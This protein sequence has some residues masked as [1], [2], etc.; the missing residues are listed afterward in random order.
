MESTNELVK[1]FSEKTVEL[2]NCFDNEDYE[3]LQL[4]IEERQQ[5]IN[6]FEQNPS[7]YKNEEI[8]LEL[9]KTNIMELNKKAEALIKK[10]MDEIKEK[11][12]DLNNDKFIRSKYN[13]DFSGNSFFFNK[14]IY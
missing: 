2:L 14:K 9:K 13:N 6:T 11:L 4:L 7:L 5:I 12:Q 3:R 8:A 1:S 10:N